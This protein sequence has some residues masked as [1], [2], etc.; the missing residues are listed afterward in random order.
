MKESGDNERGRVESKRE[1]VESGREKTRDRCWCI[2]D[3]LLLH[4]LPLSLVP[5]KNSRPVHTILS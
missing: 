2:P 3:A 4:L 1:R 5:D